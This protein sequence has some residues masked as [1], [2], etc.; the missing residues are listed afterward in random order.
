VA[1]ALID[2][3]HHF[4]DLRNHRYPWLDAEAPEKLE[5]DLSPIRRDYLT[6]DYARDV[7]GVEVVAS[8][9]VQNGWDATDPVGETRWLE[10]QAD[11]TGR[12]DAIVAYA[13]LASPGLGDVLAAHAAHP[14]VRG[15]RQILN[16]H[17]DPRYRVAP[18][19]DLILDPGWRAGFARLA[20]HRLSFDL[21]LYWP[22]MDMAGELAGS[23]PETQ[24]VLN[25]FGM[26]IDRSVEGLAAWEAAMRRL[27][28]APNVAVK[29]SGFGLGHPAWTVEDT[30][31]LLRRT[32]DLF[33]PERT[34]CGTNLPVERLFAPPT[35][36]FDAIDATVRELSHAERRMVLQGTAARIYRL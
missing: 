30:V 13:D 17:P 4:Q 27:A 18:R 7:A 8:V 10:V 35:Q 20:R 28:A 15:I 21:Q 12:P 32:V 19:P 14:R 5:G 3:H 22:Q 11:E 9:H 6:T 29:L 16:W 31:P 2:A 34:M 25:H 1:L 26:P 36:T 24:I 33:G 23:F